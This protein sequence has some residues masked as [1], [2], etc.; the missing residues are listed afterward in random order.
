MT[1][2]EHAIKYHNL[3]AS[4]IPCGKGDKRP[5]I[6]WSEYVDR[7]SSLDEIES[8]FLEK[9]NNIAM[10][11]GKISGFTVIDLDTKG[12]HKDLLEY[13][14]KL[15]FPETTT[16]RTP[17]GGYHLYYQYNPAWKTGVRVFDSV[18]VRNDGSYVLLPPS[19]NDKGVPYE[20]VSSISSAKLP[21]S[22][23]QD[24][25]YE[26]TQT[27]WSK[28]VQGVSEG[29]RNDAAAR[30]AGLYLTK[31]PPE[32]AYQALVV[33]NQQNT[34]PLSDQELKTTFSSILKREKSKKPDEVDIEALQSNYKLVSMTELLERSSK[35][36]D[37]TDPANCISTGYEWLDYKITGLFPGELLVLGAETGVGKTT[38]ATKVIYKAAL[39]QGVKSCIMALEDRLN[40]YGIKAIYFEIG[41]LRKRDG[42]KNYP[43]NEYRKNNLTSSDYKAYQAQA[44]KNLSTDK[45]FFVE[46]QEMM[47]IELLEV[48]LDTL[49]AQGFEL[50]LIDHLHYFDLLKGD[51]SKAD[52]VER[53]M[54]RLKHCQ[55]KN[56]ARIILIAHYRKL[57]GQKPTDGAF[58]D[59]MAIAQNANYII[60]LWRDKADPEGE[61][62]MFISKSRNPNGEAQ[63][64]IKY[65]VETNDYEIAGVDAVEEAWKQGVIVEE[66]GGIITELPKRYGR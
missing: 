65:D 44:I 15:G 7:K 23:G 45:I 61:T 63:I 6:K 2:Y 54:V 22:L 48:I 49:T 16:V 9:D 43:W 53:V 28:V 32:E 59:S 21:D 36:L 4:V 5:L 55:N 50:F 30:L 38:F 64:R 3:G 12:D 18:D 42:L 39:N 17:S 24:R 58:K 51:H 47:S 40:D 13:A 41:K 11:C 37:A 57:N 62:E 66:K 27:N 29:G 52:Y 19:V 25:W 14:K 60:H 56:G 1:T 35:E 26:K 33:W 31:L 10:V 20:V 46:V 34:P 8:W